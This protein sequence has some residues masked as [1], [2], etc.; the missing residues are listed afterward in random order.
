MI[1]K[2]PHSLGLEGNVEPL[3]EVLEGFLENLRGE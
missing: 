1:D 2:A 3:L